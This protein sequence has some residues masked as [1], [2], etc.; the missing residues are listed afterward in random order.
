[1]GAAG[2]IMNEGVLFRKRRGRLPFG[3]LETRDSH[4]TENIQI[5]SGSP[6]KKRVVPALPSLRRLRHTRCHGGFRSDRESPATPTLLFD[7]T[8]SAYAKLRDFKRESSHPRP[9]TGVI[10][11]TSIL[12]MR[13]S[14]AT[15]GVLLV[16]L[17][18]MHAAPAAEPPVQLYVS[19]GQLCSR[20]F[21][22]FI[23]R[24]I[25]ADMKPTLRLAG[26]S[27]GG[28]LQPISVIDPGHGLAAPHQVRPFKIDGQSVAIEGTIL[29]FDVT[30]YQIPRLHPAHRV[31]PIVEWEAPGASGTNGERQHAVAS[32]EVYVGNSWWALMWTVAIV[33]GIAAM[34]LFWG[35]RKSVQVQKEQSRFTPRP[36][37]F[38]VTGP[39]GYL[40]L[41]RA[42]LVLWTLAIASMVFLFGLL[43]LQIPEIPDSLVVLMGMSILTG[44]ISKYKA[45]K[46]FPSTGQEALAARDAAQPSVGPVKGQLADLISDYNQAYRHPEISVP[47][48]QMVLWTGVM[49]VLFIVKSWLQG[50]LWDVP[51]QMVALTGASQAGYVQDKFQPKT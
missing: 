16:C 46:D 9:V 1:M 21:T 34:V 11:N 36:F 4:F 15:M 19:D 2:G 10:M 28:N 45:R 38:V 51:W 23:N 3:T 32:A 39:D 40:S 7:A 13:R 24:E 6:Q 18:S 49:L 33:G 8:K 14:P 42:Q 20:P 29:R 48:A 41:W 31:L 25:T 17:V 37:L 30:D 35:W 27:A 47:K 43:R 5:L 26:M 22:V 12:S 44:G 50:E